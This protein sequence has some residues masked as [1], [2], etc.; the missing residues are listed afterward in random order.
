MNNICFSK[1]LS[2]ITYRYEITIIKE[3]LLGRTTFALPT[4]LLFKRPG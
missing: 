4:L 1:V 2:T 3:K